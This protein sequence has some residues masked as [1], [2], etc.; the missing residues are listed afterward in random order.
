[1]ETRMIRTNAFLLL[2]YILF[3][4]TSA[5]F[6]PQCNER[7]DEDDFKRSHSPGIVEENLALEAAAA[8]QYKSND[9][10]LS[11]PMRIAF[12]FAGT[13]RSLILPPLYQSIRENLIASFCPMEYCISDVFVRVSQSDNTHGG[14]D[15]FGTLKQGDPTNMPKI[16]YAI[17]QL[18]PQ[19]GEGMEGVTEVDWTD[20]GSAKEREEMLKSDF[21]SQTHKVLRTLDPRRY[22]MYFNRWSAYQMALRK[23][24]SIG[25]QYTWIVHTR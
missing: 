22:S 20:I 19:N 6:V 18:N 2:C 25:Y 3:I 1:M 9:I 17:S 10:V 11:K 7:C 21:N 15:S 14:L 12:V 13:P 16:E 5:K 23:E 4:S 24:I 8:E